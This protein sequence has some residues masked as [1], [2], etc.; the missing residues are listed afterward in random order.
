[1]TVVSQSSTITCP[2]PYQF[3]PQGVVMITVSG[4]V[5]LASG[6]NAAG[7]SVPIP[8]SATMALVGCE[9][10]DVRWTDDGQ[11]PSATF[12]KLLPAGTDF[13]YSGS[14]LSNMQ[15]CA[16]TGSPVLAVAFYK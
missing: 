7:K 6:V 12:G 8:L 4:V 2:A 15:F 10:N 11:K 3:D 13:W 9:T 1:M 14:P 16:V 5:T